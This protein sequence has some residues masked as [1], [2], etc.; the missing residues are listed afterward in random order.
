MLLCGAYENENP[1]RLHGIYTADDDEKKYIIP[2]D[3]SAQTSPV[4]LICFHEGRA[5]LTPS[6]YMSFI[7]T[8][9]PAHSS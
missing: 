8:G 2:R 3:G 5:S 9:S 7:G 4:G 6:W 1:A